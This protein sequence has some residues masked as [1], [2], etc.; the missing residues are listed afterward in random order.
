MNEKENTGNDKKHADFQD[1]Y[2]RSSNFSNPIKEE[3]FKIKKNGKL[4]L[5][6][7]ESEDKLN[8]TDKERIADAMDSF[9]ERTEITPGGKQE[10]DQEEK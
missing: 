6:P 2:R 3:E 8:E 4:K 10:D 9:Q 7:E 5:E 1:S